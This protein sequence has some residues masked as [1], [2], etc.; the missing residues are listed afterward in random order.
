M[1]A[2]GGREHLPTDLC[3]PTSMK[4]V[5]VDQAKESEATQTS[6]R[7]YGTMEN[8]A[9]LSLL[10]FRPPQPDLRIFLQPQH[11]AYRT[12]FRLS[13]FYRQGRTGQWRPLGNENHLCY[14]YFTDDMKTELFLECH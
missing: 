6:G 4:L 5:E 10:P 8:L 9:L 13:S 12:P 7:R 2:E 1:V 11:R 3:L 14:T